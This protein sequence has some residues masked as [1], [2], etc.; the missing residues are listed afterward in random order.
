MTRIKNA[1]SI[2]MSE[3][4]LHGAESDGVQELVKT[5]L[6]QQTLSL[7]EDSFVGT[8]RSLGR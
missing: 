8:S 6:L 3:K 4:R 2:L 7:V 5:T 1:R